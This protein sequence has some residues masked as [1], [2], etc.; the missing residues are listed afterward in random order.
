MDRRFL[1]ALALSALAVYVSQLLFPTP[2]RPAPT[3]RDSV[4]AD[5]GRVTGAPGGTPAPAMPADSVPAAARADT[6]TVTT[7]QATY[8]VSSLGATPVS[9]ELHEFPR[10]ARQGF[11]VLRRG[12]VEMVR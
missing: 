4:I 10:L 11:R 3:G 12:R 2:P 9:A 6:A 1:L 8:R 7:A 5:T